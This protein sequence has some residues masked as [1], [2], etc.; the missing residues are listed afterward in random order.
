MYGDDTPA[1]NIVV[2]LDDLSATEDGERLV[3]GLDVDEYGS[4]VATALMSCHAQSRPRAQKGS[5]WSPA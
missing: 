2:R 5:A 1:Q 3:V 4:S